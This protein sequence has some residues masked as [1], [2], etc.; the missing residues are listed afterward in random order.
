MLGVCRSAIYYEPET[1]TKR[2]LSDKELMDMIDVQYSKTPFY[3]SRRMTHALALQVGE[4]INRKRIQRLMREMGIEA[5]YP[6]P[7][8]SKRN[9]KHKIYPYLLS[10]MTIHRT[11][12]VWAADIT[13][14]RL[15]RGFAY[16]VA[17]MDW[18]S[19]KVLSWQL[20]NTMDTHFCIQALEDACERYG[21]PEYFNTDQ[22]SQFTAE[23]FTSALKRKGIKISMDG[24]G[25]A[26]DNVFTERFW[27]TIKYENIYIKGYQTITEAREGIA[28]YIDFYNNKRIHSAHKYH[29]PDQVH[30]DLVET[31]EL[32]IPDRG[33]Q[34]AA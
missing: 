7:N 13:Y 9:Q 34:S 8:T 28:D 1:P 29:T 16:L 2:I 27:R 12:Q 15:E 31:K 17:V 10:G 6:R 4:K 26:I 33:L 23:A 20:S 5:I 24:K 18:H 32:K 22:G 21:I 3:G 14:V 30:H 11:N 25:R 19:R